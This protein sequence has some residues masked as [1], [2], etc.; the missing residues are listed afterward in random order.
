MAGVLSLIVAAEEAAE[1]VN[2]ASDLYPHW[3]ELLVGALAFAILF[4]FMWKWVLPRIGA[5]LD[6]RRE[7]IQGELEQAE[8]TRSEADAL[9]ADYRTQL[10]G[11]RDE[12]NRIIEEARQ[13]ADQVRIDLQA[14]A[15]QESQ[16][17]VARAQEEIRAERD[18]VFQE[19]RSQVGEIA[20][21]LAGRVVGE[22]LDTSAHERLID[23]YIDQVTGGGA[24]N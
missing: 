21:E 7:K 3:E 5:L 17:T 8:A 4:Y 12:A 24:Q 20:V 18:R 22:S 16:A 15:E 9:L 23:E 14:K 11:A 6:E 10:A 2:E 1:E 13:T 19:L